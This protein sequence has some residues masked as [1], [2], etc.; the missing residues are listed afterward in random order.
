[1][2]QEQRCFYWPNVVRHIK[3]MRKA[4]V[5]ILT[6]FILCLTSCHSLDVEHN[7]GKSGIFYVLYSDLFL[8]SDLIQ[9]DYNPRTQFSYQN[10]DSSVIYRVLIMQDSS[11]RVIG[12]DGFSK[13]FNFDIS[14]FTPKD[15]II[16]NLDSSFLLTDPY[17]KDRTKTIKKQNESVPN[18]VDYFLGLNKELNKY[19]IIE[20][21]KHPQVNVITIVFSE[22]DYLIYKPD[23]LVFKDTNR[24]FMR[25]L[26]EDGKELDK[27]WF[28]FKNQINTDYF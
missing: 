4:I 25:F 28:Q 7:G 10:I 8:D 12:T 21:K 15:V 13:A 16:S 22:N 27:N 24:D 26:L 18:V 2:Y 14:N 3:K 1:M 5:T 9:F 19:Q 6:I 20:I 11:L 17:Q 23:S